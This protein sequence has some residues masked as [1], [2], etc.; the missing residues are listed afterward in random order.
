M[1]YFHF[2]HGEGIAV[3]CT[4][5]GS[6]KMSIG[7]SE[8][9]QAKQIVSMWKHSSGSAR[10]SPSLT[11]CPTGCHGMGAQEQSREVLVYQYSCVHS[12]SMTRRYNISGFVKELVQIPENRWSHA[13]SALPTGVRPVQTS[14]TCAGFCCCR[15]TRWI[16]QQ[17][18]LCAD[19]PPWSNS[20][21]SPRLPTKSI[22]RCSSFDCGRQT[23]G[24]WGFWWRLQI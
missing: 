16:R 24:E 20:L 15:R 9:C 22:V 2:L 4:R 12:T 6:L 3:Q 8:S 10:I 17:P 18:F 19:S 23:Q 1:S 21:D 14:P 7:E 11:L 13:C 5:C